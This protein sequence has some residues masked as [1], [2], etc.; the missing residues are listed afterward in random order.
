MP[1]K[2]RSLPLTELANLFRKPFDQQEAELKNF[3]KP[4]KGG[5]TSYAASKKCSAEA[6][7]AVGELLEPTA[8]LCGDALRQH[9][10]KIT[11]GDAFTADFN[12]PVV[13]AIS[14]WVATEGIRARHREFDA[15]PLIGSR[16]KDLVTPAIVV[17]GGQ[18]CMITLDPRRTKC[19]T[20]NGILVVQ[21]LI[22]H[23]VRAQFPELAELDIAVLQFPES[24]D[25]LDKAKGIRK[26]VVKEHALGDEQPIPFPELQAG[27]A[28]TLRIFESLR[29]ASPIAPL[30]HGM[31]DLFGRTA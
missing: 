18:G 13:E 15:V 8:P 14:R 30:D 24:R 2:G 3:V 31:E 6:C 5:L 4:V 29:K 22:H 19:L 27:V 10:L 12:W 21:S 16:R 17:R 1:S 26:R 11:K 9:L 23:L 28:E 20:R 25:W 7:G